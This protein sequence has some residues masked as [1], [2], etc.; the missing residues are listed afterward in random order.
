MKRGFIVLAALLLVVSSIFAIENGGNVDGSVVLEDGNAVPGVSVQLKG[1]NMMGSRT[2]VSNENGYFRFSN[3]NVG[4]VELV[5]ELEGFKKV[6]RRN[7]HCSLGKTTTVSIMMEMGSIQEEV[8]VH[9]TQPVVDM[10]S[11]TNQV[12][13][14]KQT[15]ET[16][17]NDRQYQ[18]IM[19]MMPGA[20]PGNNPSMMGASDSDNMYQ[21]DGMDST[22]PETKTW[23]TAMNFDNFEEMQ[24]IAQGASAEYGR[25][26]GAVINVVTKSGSNKLHGTARISVTKT[27]WNAKHAG[28][29]Y[30]SDDPTKY[31][32]ETR[33]S[34]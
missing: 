22:D 17:A 3:V 23:S 14:S 16:L 20:I 5:F 19:E 18:S 34:I 12:N 30:F 10:K 32:N 31:L 2:T 25:G 8:V 26:T 15:V 27:E 9:A 7:L 24:V 28:D 29:R 11:S 4:D 6:V 21:V 33:P 1:S 13:I